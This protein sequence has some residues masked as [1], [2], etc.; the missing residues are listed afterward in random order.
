MEPEYTHA[1]QC[2][3]RITGHIYISSAP[4]VLQ[5]KKGLLLLCLWAATIPETEDLSLSFS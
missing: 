5:N 2:H 1:I 3:E 4:S